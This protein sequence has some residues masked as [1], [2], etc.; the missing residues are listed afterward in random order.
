MRQRPFSPLDLG[1]LQGVSG[2]ALLSCQNAAKA[3]QAIDRNPNQPGWVYNARDAWSA[4]CND[5]MRRALNAPLSGQGWG[6]YRGYQFSP[7]RDFDPDFGD[8]W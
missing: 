2:G 6:D 8:G 3:Q 4:M 7:G 5:H 1:S